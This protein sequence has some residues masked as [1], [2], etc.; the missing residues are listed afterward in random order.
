M[1]SEGH[2]PQMSPVAMGLPIWNQQTMPNIVGAY[3]QAAGHLTIYMYVFLYQCS[4]A[5]A[6]F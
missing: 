5:L 1:L 2:G 6:R 4:E 3:R